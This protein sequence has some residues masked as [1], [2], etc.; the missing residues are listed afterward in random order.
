MNTL[1]ARAP[2]LLPTVFVGCPYSSPFKFADFKKCLDHLPFDWYYANTR[3]KTTHLLAILI[4]YIKAV[5]FCL[6]DL[7][8]WNANVSL[9][10]GL[11][12]GLGKN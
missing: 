3:L 5:D 6:F 7:S 8:L 1:M 9:E 11:A 4:T 2:F 10:L 12:E